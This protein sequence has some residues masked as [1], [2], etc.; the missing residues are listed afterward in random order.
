MKTFLTAALVAVG[1]F[2]QPA[3]ARD[4]QTLWPT[5][6]DT[7]PRSIFDQMRD[8][9]PR[10]AIAAP[11]QDRFAGELASVFDTIRDNAP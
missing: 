5:I 8:V 7:A 6:Q 1:L 3:V 11:D 2:S 10:S 4:I 9:T